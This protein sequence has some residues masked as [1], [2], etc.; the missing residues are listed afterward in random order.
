MEHSTR[1]QLFIAGCDDGS[2]Y[3]WQVVDDGNE[4]RIRMQ[5]NWRCVSGELK[6][7]D[8]LVQDVRGLSR[9]NIQLLEQRGAAGEP[10]VRLRETSKKVTSMLSVVSALKKPSIEEAPGSSSADNRVTEPLE[11]EQQEHTEHPSE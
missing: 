6:V 3:M 11:H 2:V 8:A 5:W 4:C 1:C 10:S 7:K 9:L